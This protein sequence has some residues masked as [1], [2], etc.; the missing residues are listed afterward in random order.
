MALIALVFVIAN[1]LSVLADPPLCT[2][3]PTEGIWAPWVDVDVCTANCGLSGTISQTRVCTTEALG[4]PCSGNTARVSICPVTV[5]PGTKD[6]QCTAPYAK[7]V[8]YA[9]KRNECGN[10][11]SADDNAAPTCTLNPCSL[12]L[13]TVVNL[14]IDT[15]GT[16]GNTAFASDTLSTDGNGCSVRTLTCTST[17]TVLGL[18]QAA[19][20]KVNGGI[21]AATGTPTASL[22]MTCSSTGL[23]W[24]YSGPLGITTDVAQIGCDASV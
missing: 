3:C 5:C 2:G 24:Q 18:P 16:L 8:N 17:K 4:C 6:A 22:V 15:T 1:V 21:T 9:N 13:N 14:P 11:T 20:I 19:N 12:C 10:A 23:G 7:Y